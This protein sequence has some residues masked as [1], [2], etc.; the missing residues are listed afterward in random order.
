MKKTNEGPLV[1][2]L[3]VTISHDLTLSPER[4]GIRANYSFVANDKTV[5]VSGE[6]EDRLSRY[7]G[8]A[9]IKRMRKF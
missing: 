1:W 8:S 2:G 9:L 3:T 5:N 7:F 4:V 6:F